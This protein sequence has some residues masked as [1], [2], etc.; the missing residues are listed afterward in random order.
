MRKKLL[1]IL[2]VSFGLLQAQEVTHID[3]D[4]NNADIVFNSWNTS[5]TFSKIMNPHID[6]SNPNNADNPSGF[7]GQFT[8]GS[9]NGIGIGIINSTSV[10]QMPFNLENNA[11]FS[12]K[13][14]SEEEIK[15]TFHLEN[16]PD[17]GN[18]LEVDANIGADDINKWTTL[19]FDFSEYS[20][21]YMN[22]I[23]I[24]IGGDNTQSGDTYLFD[25][26]KGPEMYTAPA[27]MLTPKSGSED[28]TI[29]TNLEI[30]TNSKFR[31]LDDS[32]ISDLSTII[33]IKKGDEN[34]DAVAFTAEINGDKNKIT[35]NPTN[36]LEN[37]T[38]YWYGIVDGS[39]EY[40]TDTAVTGVHASFTTKAAVTG[41]INEVL[42]DFDANSGD[43][44]F[45]SWG[46]TEFAKIENP[47]KSGINTSDYVGK[48]IHGGN[49]SGLQNNLVDEKTTLEPFDF[50]ETPFIKVKV[51][52]SKPVAV[53]V[54]LQN[55]PNWWEG[56]EQKIEVTETGKWV[57]VVF[58]FGAI[59]AS[60]YDRAQIYFDKERVAGSEKGDIFYFD[61]YMKSNVAPAVEKSMSPAQGVTDVALNAKPTLSSNFSFR[62][63]DNTTITDISAHVEL[64]ENDATGML[65]PSTASLDDS[66]AKITITPNELLKT[67]TTYW[68][69]IVDGAIEYKENDT[70]V[71]DFH[72]TFTT[73]ATEIAISMYNDFDGVNLT[74]MTE[75]MGD[76]AAMLETV[77]DPT[78]ANNMVGKWQKGDSWG[79]WER[80]HLELNEAF[81]A[82]QGDFF[83]FR[84][85]SPVK[86]GIR[87]K[88]ANAKEDGDIVA[89]LEVD[90]EIIFEN[91]WQTVYLNTS[92]LADGVDF[93][94]IFIFLGRGASQNTTFYIDDIK[95]PALKGTASIN[96]I[97]K[98]AFGMYPNPASTHVQF[99]NVEDGAAVEILD[100]SAKVV[101]RTSVSGNSISVENLQP[102]LYII[103]VNGTYQKLIKQ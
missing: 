44:G 73:T 101:H 9:D 100:S 3:F 37:G 78:D 51:W 74:T 29:N 79:G 2:L 88:V 53:S 6:P 86:T 1:S 12:M 13:V 33:S 57:E 90:E 46:G 24:K 63:L 55:E 22:N 82:S 4:T 93:K 45:S 102:G 50:S 99:T 58:N 43:I 18:N 83:S 14:F 5:S 30:T 75:T 62:N 85:Y 42:F 76:P 23:V 60:N 70:A 54:K 87:F 40:D 103:G 81:D 32:D 47:D 34:G 48:Y 7:V 21:I 16:S 84:V 95:G 17:W 59:T 35:I 11:V 94:H 69:G 89:Q 10:F 56:H 31:N 77:A 27:L 68:Y 65:V 28:I 15:V 91:Q 72:G 66:N 80:I 71:T 38:T 96:S 98:V 64:R 36:D 97:G 52:V 20:N 39:I 41:D 8:A 49:D 67:S 92:E 61:D 19:T 26:I 25:D